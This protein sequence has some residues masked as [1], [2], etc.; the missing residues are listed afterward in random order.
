M[1]KRILTQNDINDI[2]NSYVNEKKTVNKIS[3]EKHLNKNKI[4][5]VLIE[6]GITLRKKG[7][8]NKQ[9]D[10]DIMLNNYK[11]KKYIAT[12]EYTYIAI[13]K[14]DKKVQFSD[15]MN[16]SGCLSKYIKDTYNIEPLSNY[17][18]RKYYYETNNYWWEQWFDIIKVQIT[19][20]PNIKINDNVIIE[21]YVNEKMTV[22]KIASQ[23][24]IGKKRVYEIL[25]AN[26]IKL[27]KKGELNKKNNFEIKS[28]SDNPKY[29][30]TDSKRYI[31]ISKIDNRI[32][33]DYMNH[34]GQLTSYL[35]D[36]L[37]IKIPSLYEM[38]KYYAQTNN[39]WWE[40]WFEI[41]EIDK[42]NQRIKCPY[43]DWESIDVNNKSGA[44]CN[45]IKKYHN[46]TYQDICNEFP[47]YKIYFK[48]DLNASNKEKMLKNKDNYVTCPICNTKLEMLTKSHLENKHGITYQDF[49]TQYPNYKLI[50]NRLYQVN[51]ESA[52]KCNL[53]VSKNRFVSKY[54]IELQNFL[55]SYN[56]NFETNRQILIGKEIDILI[57]SKMIGI[58]FNGLYFHSEWNGNKKHTYHRDKSDECL[59][60]GYSLIHIFED[61]LVY[62]KD[63]VLNKLKHILNLD[64]NLPRIMGRKCNIKEIYK[65]D[66]EVFLNKYHIQGYSASS[67]YIGAFYNDELIAVMSFKNGNIKNPNWELTRFASNYN[68]ICQGIGGKLFNFFIK[69][70]NPDYIISFADRR[71]TPNPSNNLYIKLGFELERITPPDYKYINPKIDKFKR[72]HKMLFSK[73][74]LSKLYGFP[75]TMTEKEM[76]I[77]AGFDRIWDCGL[78]KYVWIND[79]IKER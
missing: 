41:K 51:S 78:F 56:I 17:K 11:N 42:K 47:K 69:K 63:I 55:K 67:I 70:Y 32:F 37:N 64:N 18:S 19:E 54:E 27:R 43:C 6:N 58:E 9:Y 25:K 76:A 73:S 57:P 26:N 30:E 62:R 31:A 4:Y 20:K 7:E 74:K 2:I 60:K 65:H 10:K 34:S 75:L 12:D 39:Y 33:N 22:D 77:K 15:Y 45:H 28:Y 16:K 61:E 1:K 79:K 35:R 52:K 66:A 49:I 53:I 3:A 72:F 14:D 44:L 8:L 68:Y 23:L 24:H 46:K 48:E 38:K 36:K 59:K 5:A 40:Q 21:K 29:V 13:S 50:S 71:W